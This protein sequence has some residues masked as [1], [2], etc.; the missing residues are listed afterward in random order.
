MAVNA[1]GTKIG[2]APPE[3]HRVKQIRLHPV[4]LGRNPAAPTEI[5]R[6]VGGGVHPKTDGRPHLANDA[7][8]RL[9]LERLV[10]MSRVLGTTIDV[11]DNVGYID[12]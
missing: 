6:P 12:L 4:N 5:T 1:A 3:D 11:R 8:G 2:G 9:I 10:R 7:D